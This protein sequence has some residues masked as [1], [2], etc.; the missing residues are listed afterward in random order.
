MSDAKWYDDYYSKVNNKFSSWNL[1]ILELIKD[2]YK[3]RLK[4]LDCG[5]G[6]GGLLKK[7]AQNFKI[8]KNYL[9]GIDQSKVAI[10]KLKKQGFKNVKA[11]NLESIPYKSNYFDIIVLAEVIEHLRD[12][13]KV[14]LEVYR[15]LK[16]DGLLIISFPNYLNL[17]WLILRL[18]AK[19]LN[20][21]NWIILQPY[22]KI[23]SYF[24]IK[25]YIARKGFAFI[26][27]SGT[28]YLPP[29]LYKCEAMKLSNSLSR[30]SL[31]FLSFHPVLV[32]KKI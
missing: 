14:I 26:K 27:S 15:C 19:F 32:F 24:G 23:Y 22:D 29:I 2:S 7:L 28:C 17:P 8:N 9:Y 18:L 13:D 3:K 1:K 6:D 16:K 20:K 12:K 25:R 30:C 11:S 4:I 21:P 10:N 31:A 5:C